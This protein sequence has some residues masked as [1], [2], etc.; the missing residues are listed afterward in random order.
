MPKNEKLLPFGLRHLGAKSQISNQGNQT[1]ASGAKSLEPC[2]VGFIQKR[3][4]QNY[5]A[6]LDIFFMSNAS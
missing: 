4:T 5:I 6:F 3:N 2:F 1:R